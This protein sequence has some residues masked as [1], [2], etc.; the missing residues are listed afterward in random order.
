MIFI[1]YLNGYC[2]I[3]CKYHKYICFHANVWLLI[4]GLTNYSGTP[5]LLIELEELVAYVPL[6]GC[7]I[8]MHIFIKNKLY[9]YKLDAI[10]YL[11]F[12]SSL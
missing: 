4:M 6:A 8:E 10:P 7:Y 11:S 9:T 2:V 1:G 3:I 12:Q 5:R